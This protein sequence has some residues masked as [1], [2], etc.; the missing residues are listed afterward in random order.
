MKKIYTGIALGLFPIFNMVLWIHTFSSNTDLPYKEKVNVF[1]GYLFNI[2]SLILIFI[3]IVFSILS[4]LILLNNIDKNTTIKKT[5]AI[6]FSI[7]M[8]IIIFLNIWFLL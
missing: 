2:P 8:F 6:V 1:L 4:A 7:I 5:I 3:N